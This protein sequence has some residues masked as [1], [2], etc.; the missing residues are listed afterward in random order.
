MK[1]ISDSNENS[2]NSL[3]VDK[4]A[5]YGVHFYEIKRFNKNFVPYER[6]QSALRAQ[7]ISGMC[8]KIG[9]ILRFVLIKKAIEHSIV[10]SI[11]LSKNIF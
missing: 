9:F 3:L 4:L 1:G 2:R 8:C 11:T 7:Q 5:F 6:K 10:Y